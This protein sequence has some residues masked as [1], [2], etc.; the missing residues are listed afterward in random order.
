MVKFYGSKSLSLPTNLTVI[1][2]KA[3]KIFY[4]RHNEEFRGKN[5]ASKFLESDKLPP[6]V[7]K[8]FSKLEKMAFQGIKEGRLVFEGHEVRGMEDNALFHRLPD[9]RPDTFERE[10]KFCSIH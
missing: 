9:R 5:F 1:Y 4:F 3:V 8:K 7:E 6:E 2:K 10:E